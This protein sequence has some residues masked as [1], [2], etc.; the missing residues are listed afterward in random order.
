MKV[1]QTRVQT[2]LEKWAKTINRIYRGINASIYEYVKIVRLTSSQGMKIKITF[3]YHVLKT[4]IESIYT[5]GLNVCECC[6]EELVEQRKGTVQRR[7]MRE[8]EGVRAEGEI[9][10]WEKRG[11]ACRWAHPWLQGEPEELIRLS[12]YRVVEVSHVFK[13]LSQGRMIIQKYESRLLFS[14]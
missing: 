14:I 8:G 9:A 13:L 1:L 11:C 6:W 2:I 10:E 5:A 12:F 3:L 4:K 7:E